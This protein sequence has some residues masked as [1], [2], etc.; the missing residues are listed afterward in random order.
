MKLFNIL[1]KLHLRELN[2]FKRFLSSPFFNQRTDVQLLL[3]VWISE[4]KR[5]HP[6]KVYW[7]K[8]FPDQAFDSKKWNM[9]ASRLFRLLEEFLAV[10]EMRQNEAQKKFYLAKVYRK[11][12]HEKLFKN[13]VQAADHSLEK[14]IFRSTDYLQGIYDLSFEKYDY[15]ISLNRKE[16]SNLQE[17]SD[18]LDNYSIA[19]KLR[20]ACYALSR[21]I[22]N[23][24]SYKIDMLE[25][26][27]NYVESNPQ[28]L[29][30]PAIAIFYN[31]YQAINS[32][33]HERFF[34]QLREAIRKYQELFPP[35]ELRD[36]YTVV[37]NYSIKKL[38]TGSTLF[39]KEAFELYVLSLEQG[40]LLEDGIM[41][42]STFSNI[43]SLASKLNKHEWAYDFIHQYRQHLKPSYKE[44]LFHYSL[45]KLF[46]VQGQLEQSLQELIQ[47]ET[48]ASFLLLGA[49]VLQLKIYFE[50]EEFDPLESLLESLR[51]YLQRSKDLGYRKEHYTNVI[52]FTRQLLQL[53]VMNKKE[54]EA[55]R[56]RVSN[57][58]IF[59]EK[60]WFLKQI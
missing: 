11:I 43:V 56:Q 16:K 59:A 3:N 8:I 26:A 24:E 46:Y 31:C 44:P 51:V 20:L 12:Q 21:Q 40:Y 25:E 53:P 30:I 39:I 29:E 35:S 42:E 5:R 7:H 19:T 22:I 15:I 47:V 32:K 1:N 33:D 60:D 10:N 4:Q 57:T 54:K 18:N 28:K 6:P 49:K 2:T 50:L 52:T 45:G 17:V 41:L 37:I 55:F 58:E 36:I 14:Q 13:A 48:K 23:Q 38:N 9:L 34:I 27:I